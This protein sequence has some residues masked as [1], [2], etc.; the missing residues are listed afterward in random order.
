M[1]GPTRFTVVVRA[2]ATPLTATQKYGRLKQIDTETKK[3]C[4][5]RTRLRD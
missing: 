3:R 5:K 4:S 2:L 1:R